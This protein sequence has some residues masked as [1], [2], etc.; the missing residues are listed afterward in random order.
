MPFVLPPGGYPFQPSYYQIGL[1]GGIGLP[2][3]PGVGYPGG[4]DRRFP[5]PRGG[6]QDGGSGEGVKTEAYLTVRWSSAL[7]IRQA[8]VIEEFGSAG[9]SSEKARTRIEAQPKEYLIHVAGIPSALQSQNTAGIEKRLLKT[10]ML[11]VKGRR[12]VRATSV[13]VPEHGLHLMAA[14]HF[15][16]F[17][18]LAPAEGA[19]EFYAEA[20]PVKIQVVSKLKSMVYGG[21]LEL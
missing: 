16:R 19:V 7:P 20:G 4:S 13:E 3:I 12:S 17:E 1:P 5:I 15:P 9:V 21:V 2:R 14:L 11:S 8:L 10:A 18:G 6:G